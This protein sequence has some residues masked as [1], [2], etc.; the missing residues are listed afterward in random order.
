L[1]PV[2]SNEIYESL[3]N[4]P[5][6]MPPSEEQ[7]WGLTIRTAR[8][9]LCTEL[10]STQPFH[11]EI[12]WRWHHINTQTRQRKTKTW[13]WWEGFWSFHTKR[14]LWGEG[15]RRLCII[16]GTY[17]CINSLCPMRRVSRRIDPIPTPLV[18]LTGGSS[19]IPSMEYVMLKDPTEP[20]HI[21]FNP[22][23][24]HTSHLPPRRKWKRAT[25]P[26]Q[27]ISGKIKSL[28]F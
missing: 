12:D 15:V 4:S 17:E 28:I 14:E 11:P 5:F 27:N 7:K 9:P 18:R 22:F 20:K 10:L 8:L 25:R 2:I 1:L 16:E 26:K 23:I 24:F 21:T 3:K 13:V 19:T 6:I